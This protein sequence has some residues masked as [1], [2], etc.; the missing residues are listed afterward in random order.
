MDEKYTQNF[1][2]QLTEKEK[3]KREERL[4]Y[5]FRQDPRLKLMIKRAEK[6]LNKKKDKKPE[7]NEE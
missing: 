7:T 4:L 1:S 5:L 2:N 3:K 6:K